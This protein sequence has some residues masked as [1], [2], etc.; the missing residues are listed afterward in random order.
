M[1]CEADTTHHYEITDD[2]F[3][4]VLAVLLASIMERDMARS[5]R[6]TLI[7]SY[8]NLVKAFSTF[9]PTKP[10]I[11]ALIDETLEEL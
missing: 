3:T 9:H 4:T 10:A 11:L 1:A 7:K 5:T 2:D 6:R 8:K